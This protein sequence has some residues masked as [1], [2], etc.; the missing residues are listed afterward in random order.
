MF[1]MLLVVLGRGWTVHAVFIPPF[2]PRFPIGAI[3]GGFRGRRSAAAIVTSGGAA[4]FGA[5]VRPP[6]L[7]GLF[8]CAGQG[9]V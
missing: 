1:L 2:M 9:L 3:T 5:V 8:R 7:T 6:P 4:V